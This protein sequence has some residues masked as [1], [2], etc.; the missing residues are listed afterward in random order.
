MNKTIAEVKS[1]LRIPDDVL[2]HILIPYI[3]TQ[4]EKCRSNYLSEEELESLIKKKVSYRRCEECLLHC[5]HEDC[6]WVGSEEEFDDDRL[7]PN[8]HDDSDTEV[9]DNYV[10]YCIDCRDPILFHQYAFDIARCTECFR[11]LKKKNSS[12]TRCGGCG[13][14]VYSKKSDGLCPECRTEEE[15]HMEKQKQG[16]KGMILSPAI[17]SG[18]ILSGASALAGLCIT[19]SIFIDQDVEQ[20]LEE[21]NT[22]MEGAKCLCKKASLVAVATSG[23]FL[24][25][26]EAN[27]RYKRWKGR[28]QKR[29]RLE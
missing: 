9:D 22:V 27:Y 29:Q 3:A 18:M 13:L 16:L 11:E 26:R 17:A 12:K 15:E 25:G 2:N 1:T 21:A 14:L 4:C 23:L 6:D 10:Y 19:N 28:N 20:G 7:C 5:R 24:L 8:H